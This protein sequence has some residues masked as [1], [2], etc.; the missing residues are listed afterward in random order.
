ART[1]QMLSPLDG[2]IG[3]D[4]VVP[5][6]DSAHPLIVEINPRLTTSYLGYR[7][8]AAENLAA[9]MLTPSSDS[10]WQWLAGDVDFAS[11]GTFSRRLA[12][13]LS[14]REQSI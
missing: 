11:D 10:L 14:E 8:L 1:C 7:K 6:D 9:R 2:Y 12:P 5:V 3:F 13:I 4:I